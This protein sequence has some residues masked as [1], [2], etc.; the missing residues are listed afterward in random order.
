MVSP[1]KEVLM[2][3]V[4]PTADDDEP[5]AAAV[6]EV[7]APPEVDVVDWEPGEE[8]TVVDEPATG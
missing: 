4:E 7:T 8:V 5:A 3:A 1:G 6:V 2:G